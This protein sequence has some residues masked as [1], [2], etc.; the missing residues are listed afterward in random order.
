MIQL[1]LRSGWQPSRIGKQFWFL[2]W[3][4]QLIQI[5]TLA[6]EG[7]AFLTVF[8]QEKSLN[9]KQKKLESKELSCR[10]DISWGCG[11]SALLKGKKKSRPKQPACLSPHCLFPLISGSVKLAQCYR[12]LN[13]CSS[14]VVRQESIFTES[15]LHFLELHWAFT[16]PQQNFLPKDR[17][18]LFHVR[19]Q[20]S[21]Q[22]VVLTV[23]SPHYLYTL[24]S[25]VDKDTALH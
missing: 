15:L 8:G 16:N 9:E 13:T 10:S 25:M 2:L 19:N 18:M 17:L 4:T 24:G 1:T 23:L 6:P 22:A 5:I 12:Q 3:P 20:T 14:Q 21:L 7:A 11:C